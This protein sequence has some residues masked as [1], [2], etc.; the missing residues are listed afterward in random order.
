LQ[1]LREGSKLKEKEEK[2]GNMYALAIDGELV[3]ANLQAGEVLKNLKD[4]KQGERVEVAS[5][6]SR[7]RLW[8]PV[9]LDK[10]AHSA[11]MA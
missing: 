7:L 11:S 10:F 6:D 2:G 1:S 3:A 8:I 9:C 5:F 4:S